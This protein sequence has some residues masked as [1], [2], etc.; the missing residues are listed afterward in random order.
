MQSSGGLQASPAPANAAFLVEELA[1]ME[2]LEPADS[3]ENQRLEKVEPEHPAL[4]TRVRGASESLPRNEVLLIVDHELQ[5]LPEEED[6]VFKRVQV[7][8]LGDLMIHQC[9]A[10]VD[11]EA[12]GFRGQGR[13]SVAEAHLVLAILVGDEGEAVVR[14]S[15]VFVQSF[16]ESV[17]NPQID[18]Q[19][20][21]GR[22][23]VRTD[24]L[25][26][27]LDSLLETLL[28]RST[29]LD[30]VAVGQGREEAQHDSSA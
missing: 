30:D 15:Q 25:L 12:H 14:I 29:D 5:T 24:A 3:E 11:V 10:H 23:G 28:A 9:G 1:K 22:H 21:P 6:G 7:L 20:S 4:G 26:P 19:I 27:T 17:G 13:H 8:F 16:P 2:H 18:V